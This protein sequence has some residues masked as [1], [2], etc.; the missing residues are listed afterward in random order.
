MLKRK[1]DFK[2]LYKCMVVSTLSFLGTLS[3]KDEIY[4]EFKESFNYI[5]VGTAL[6]LPYPGF[7]IGHREKFINGSHAFD[8]SIS[9]YSMIVLQDVSINTK[10]ISYFK[11]NHYVSLGSC[12]YLGKVEDIYF[13]CFSPFLSYG[14]EYEKSFFEA[15]FSPIRINNYGLDF[16]PSLMVKYGFKY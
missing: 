7:A 3:A 12:S 11:N 13:V 6:P 10:F 14:K 15:A 2:N 16:L 9:Y 4:T 5:E 1:S 8:V